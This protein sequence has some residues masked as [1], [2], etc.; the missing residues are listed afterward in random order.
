MKFSKPS[1]LAIAACLSCVP[2][3]AM[4]QTET[5]A[6]SVQPEPGDAEQASAADRITSIRV[7]GAERLEAN[8][9]LSYVSIRVGE[10]YTAQKGDQILR[11]LAETGLFSSYIVRNDQGIVT[12]E[13]IE[14][15]VINRI[16]LEGNDRVKSDKI[17]PEIHLS[18]RQ[19][20]TRAKVR[21][22]VSRIIELYKRQG[23]FS[24]TVEPK[25]VELSQNRVDVIFEISEGPKSKI[26]Q[27]NILGNEAFTDNEL[28][29]EMVT[30]EARITTFL[31]SNTSYDPDRLAF[32]QQKLRQF[33]LTQGYA[34]F[35]VVS[36]VAEL[37]PDN[38]NFIITYVVEEGPRYRFGKVGVESEIRDLDESALQANIG[39]AGGDWYDAQRVE[40]YVEQLSS[41]AGAFGYA[42][43]EA[44]PKFVRNPDT[45]TM[46]VEFRLQETPRVYVERVNINGNTL[47]QDK[48]VRREFRV[49]EG[50]AFNSL[51]VKRSAARINSLGFFQEGLEIQQKE[52]SAA[53]RIV[54]EANVIEQPTGE[55]QL[56]AGFSS[57]EG[58]ILSG[59]IK[60]RNFRGRGQTV[61][62]SANYSGSSKSASLSFTEPYLFDR[63]VSLGA[64]VYLKTYDNSS[65]TSDESATYEQVTNGAS[66]R[67]GVPLTEYMSFI[68]SYTLNFENL[69][70]DEATYFADLD[71][72]GQST[73]E[74]LLA[75]RYL[76]DAVGSRVSSIIGGTIK[77]N[78]LNNSY[79]PTSGSSWSLGLEAAG[80][81]GDTKYVRVRGQADRYWDLGTGFILSSH[82]EGGYIH[83]LGDGETL[84]TDRFFLGESSMRGFDLRGLGPAVERTYLVSDD[85]GNATAGTV[86]RDALG[87]NAYYLSRTELEIPLGTGI[88]ELGL[89]P[90]IF[91][92]IGSVFSLS[93]PTLSES[94]FPDGTFIPTRD[95]D[96]NALYSQ[97]Y[98]VADD[99]TVET[100]YTTD[101]YAP[102]GSQ[103]TAIRSTVSP[104]TEEYVGDTWKPRITVGVGVNWN[105][106]MGPLR[107]N[108]S[109]IIS[110]QPSD[111]TKVFSFS[112]G[113]SF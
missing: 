93:P 79:R 63:N 112:M 39:I 69:S 34:D 26:R 71:G 12:I 16:M 62:L 70:L 108:L 46:D 25:M 95:D 53:D 41:L 84:Y 74:P 87:G 6:R 2:T 76:C 91:L 81:G 49:V 97:S 86:N 64:D 100:I 38:E 107:F 15:P 104:F 102:D 3:N 48:V 101:Q 40:N 65:S 73:C 28:K 98:D 54:L 11:E 85:D 7:V 30:K 42:F 43:A 32:D 72:D 24:A 99:G 82:A 55:L 47:T 88:S 45:L 83:N 58:F 27:I 8:T 75:G 4:A 19:I 66:I 109:H 23:R 111:D 52:G 80:L 20:F 50:D 92:D 59:G 9:I 17:L 61:G 22:D 44:H 18:P 90:S 89:R 57:T 60:Q 37:T 67:V 13:I 110:S 106:P 1:L 56:S 96:G 78:G 5:G 113:T 33:Y 29:A 31:S 21:A 36:A 14:N 103:N 68:G 77:Y 51:S 94:P 10:T 105:S 35:R